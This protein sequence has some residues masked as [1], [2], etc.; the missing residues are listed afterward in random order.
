MGS[1]RLA[2]QALGIG[3]IAGLRSMTAPA[4]ITRAIR[5][6]TAA[7]IFAVLAAGELI[8]DKLPK[9]PSRIKPGPL[10]ARIISGALSAAALYSANNRPAR[11]GALLGGAGALA[12]SFGGFGARRLIVQSLHVPDPVIAVAEDVLAVAG[13][14]SLA[15]Q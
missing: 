11:Y 9:I 4:I 7:N 6:K 5:R 2:A 13:G 15:R 10:T 3:A 8:A 12:G 1:K 14:Y